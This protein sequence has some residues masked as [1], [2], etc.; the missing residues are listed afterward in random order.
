MIKKEKEKT[1][2]PLFDF[3]TC[4]FHIAPVLELLI[5][6]N[7][8]MLIIAHE[9]YEALCFCQ[10]FTMLWFAL[11]IHTVNYEVSIHFKF[12]FINYSVKHTVEWKFPGLKNPT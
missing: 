1:E 9:M 6:W 2:F 3:Y 10:I 5:S 11:R 4:D 7:S 8:G 12:P